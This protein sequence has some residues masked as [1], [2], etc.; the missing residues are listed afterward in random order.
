MCEFFCTRGAGP[1]ISSFDNKAKTAFKVWVMNDAF[2]R[3]GWAVLSNRPLSDDQRKKTW[4]FKV[5]P[6]TKAISLYSEGECP[7]EVVANP[8]QCIG[9]ERAAVWCGSHIEDRLRDMFAGVENEWVRLLAL[10]SQQ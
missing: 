6:M 8:S 2:K 5:D 10:P 4:F 3:P 1:D 9:L 7:E